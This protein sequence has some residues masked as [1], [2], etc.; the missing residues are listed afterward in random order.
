MADENTATVYLTDDSFDTT[1]EE[2]Q[3][4]GK[5]VFVDFFA[6]WCGPCKMAAPI[7]DKLAEEYEGKVIIAKLNVDENRAS[8]QKYSVMSIPT[9]IV[10]KDGEKLDSKVGFIGEDGYRDMIESALS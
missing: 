2:A 10:F 4:A 6:D 1:L 8:A 7:V 3:K 9:V 5:P